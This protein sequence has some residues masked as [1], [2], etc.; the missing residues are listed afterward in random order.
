MTADHL[1]CSR[2]GGSMTRGVVVDRGN[3]SLPDTQIWVSGAP[4]RSFLSGLKLKGRE[5]LTVETF[6]CAACGML[7]S[8]AQP[9]HIDQREG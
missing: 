4:E 3:E 9:R 1:T 6:R 5:V 7:E 2:C 8:Y